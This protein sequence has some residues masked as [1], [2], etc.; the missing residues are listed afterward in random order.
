[1]SLWPPAILGFGVGMGINKIA[2]MAYPELA[3]TK[4]YT[5]IEPTAKDQGSHTGWI[6]KH[7]HT[8]RKLQ[9]KMINYSRDYEPTE[10]KLRTEQLEMT[11]YGLSQNTLVK[12]IQKNFTEK[13]KK[14]VE[15]KKL[16]SVEK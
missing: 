4:D 5:T 15:D 14:A 2:R 8:M 16:K 7:S 10:T 13:G 11:E 12:W 1:M 9:N 3:K 6:T